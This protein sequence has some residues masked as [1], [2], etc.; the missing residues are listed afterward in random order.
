MSYDNKM[1]F[2]TRDNYVS[3]SVIRKRIKEK[4]NSFEYRQAVK[5]LLSG[6]RFYQLFSYASCS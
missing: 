6:K 3:P 1:F 2:D 5:E 4:M